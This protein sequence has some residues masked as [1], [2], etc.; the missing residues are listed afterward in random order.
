MQ[1]V[2]FIVPVNQKVGGSR[3]DARL[4]GVV[5]ACLPTA[6]WAASPCM[7]PGAD[8]CTPCVPTPATQPRHLTVAAGGHSLWCPSPIGLPVPL[9][10]HL[11]VVVGQIIARAR[12]ASCLIWAP[13]AAGTVV[14]YGLPLVRLACFAHA[15]APPDLPGAHRRDS[16]A[17]QA[18]IGCMVPLL[19]QMRGQPADVW[20]SRLPLFIRLACRHSMYMC[21]ADV[22]REL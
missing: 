18:S 14:H 21:C 4:L 15:A 1:R 17:A 19:L 8:Q 20:A 9:C 22:R 12:G 5:S 3:T 16:D 10:C 7:C 11:W 13:A 2:G 6:C